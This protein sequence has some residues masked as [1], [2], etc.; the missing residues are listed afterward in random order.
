M[1]KE[2]QLD[3]DTQALLAWCMQ[4]EQQLIARGATEREAQEHIEEQAEWYTD[5]FYEGYTPEQ[6]AQ[7][8]MN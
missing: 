6:A 2:P 8:A 3:D 5:L 1:K 7:E 4:V